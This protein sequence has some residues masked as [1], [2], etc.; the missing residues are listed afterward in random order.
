MQLG[1]A[2]LLTGVTNVS[3]VCSVATCSMPQYHWLMWKWTHP[4]DFIFIVPH[5]DVWVHEC[6]VYA[7]AFLWVNDQHLRQQV[8]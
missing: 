8:T 4:I 6:L 5:I 1:W 7:D 3:R 2:A